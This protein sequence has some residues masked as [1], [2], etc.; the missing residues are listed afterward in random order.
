MVAAASQSD[1]YA[2]NFV[3][4]NPIPVARLPRLRSF[5]ITIRSIMPL[6]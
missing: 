3:H 2:V 5:M 1:A 6:P 4:E